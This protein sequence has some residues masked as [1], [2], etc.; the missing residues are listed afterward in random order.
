MAYQCSLIAQIPL[1]VKKEK[2]RY[3]KQTNKNQGKK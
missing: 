2:Q 1:V 3:T